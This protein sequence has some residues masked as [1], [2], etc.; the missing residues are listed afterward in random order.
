M[1]THQLS[2]LIAQY[3]YGQ[4]NILDNGMQI[5]FDPI[6]RQVKFDPFYHHDVRQ[7]RG[8]CAELMNTAYL[9]IRER[10]PKVH[11]TRVEGNDPDFFI[12]PRDKHCFLFV[13]DEDLMDGQPYTHEPKDIEQVVSQ[14]PLIVDPSFQRVVP[15][16]DSGYSVQKLRNQGCKITY[17]NTRVLN[18]NQ[19]VP[20]GI[21]SQGEIVYFM[22]NFDS[23]QLI[24]IGLQEPGKRAKQYRLDSTDLDQLFR[25]DPQIQ[26]FIDLL[27]RREYFETTQSFELEYNIVIE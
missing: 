19:G 4:F 20:L 27:K 10:H 2:D 26:R 6:T 13:S 7:T 14:N 21:N 11:V 16:S 5:S 23:P 8:S 25:E 15:L 18:H 3:E 1:N 12:R 17:S 22:V 9:D 24:D